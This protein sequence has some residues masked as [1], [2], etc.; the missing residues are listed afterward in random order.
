MR[1]EEMT[2]TRDDAIGRRLR[3][4]TVA[5]VL[6]D[7]IDT[8]AWTVS[9]GVG[10]TIASGTGDTEHPRT[11][12]VSVPTGTVYG[13]V[14]RD[15]LL[16][17]TGNKFLSFDIKVDTTFLEVSVAL[18]VGDRTFDAYIE[19]IVF[20]ENDFVAGQWH[21]CSVPLA[22]LAAAG[23]YATPGSTALRNV[24]AVRIQVFPTTGNATAVQIGAIQL[25]ETSQA[26][27]I[28]FMFDDGWGTTYS[29]AFPYLQ[30]AGL[31]G[32]V[33]VAKD[34]VGTTGMVTLAQL[35]EMYAAGW[36]MVN[37]SV[38]HNGMDGMTAA[39][40]QDE[41]YSCTTYLIANGMPSDARHFV[42][43]GGSWDTT[44]LAEVRKLVR[45]ARTAG[46][47]NFV[48]PDV[49]NLHLLRPWYITSDV[50][51]ATAETAIDDLADRGGIMYLTFHNI[52]PTL[53]E[54][55]E[56]WTT[57]NF[58]ALVDYVHAKGIT[59]YRPCDIWGD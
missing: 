49:G 26:P 57:A 17:L 5:R 4:G 12:I 24:Q 39:E 23:N 2:E 20:Q 59:A 38:T 29:T 13:E 40:V 16:D 27:G 9:N 47:Q 36:G 33:A 3:Y 42:Y 1:G 53:D 48:T 10:V 7:F 45:T 22:Q 52:L 56:T 25:H 14:T 31:I 6:E 51:L 46:N 44:V 32:N 34:L 41:I 18:S 35:Q 37:H 30:A 8:S 54:Q 28:V 19:N 11:A 43:P 15:V 50:T 58:Q 55:A 21:R